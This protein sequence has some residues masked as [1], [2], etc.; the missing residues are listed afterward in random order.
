VS[1]S[2]LEYCDYTLGA[3]LNK[4]FST[5]AQNTGVT[6]SF[7]EEFKLAPENELSMK[8]N[9]LIQIAKGES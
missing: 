7:M 6:Q 2:L 5:Q 8:L 1:S 4:E 3:I 9:M